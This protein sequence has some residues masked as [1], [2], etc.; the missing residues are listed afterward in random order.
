[1]RAIQG[2]ESIEAPDEGA[3]PNRVQRPARSADLALSLRSLELAADVAASTT[4]QVNLALAEM[5]ALARRVEDAGEVP[6]ANRVLAG[7]NRKIDMLRD[8]LGATRSALRSQLS[9]AA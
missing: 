5:N 8:A 2:T 3:G 7:I 9:G 1:V 6:E 4:E